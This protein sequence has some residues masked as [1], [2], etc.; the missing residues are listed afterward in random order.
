MIFNNETLREVIAASAEDCYPAYGEFDTH[1]IELLENIIEDVFATRDA[2]AE[3]EAI[4]LDDFDGDI[5]AAYQDVA[6]DFARE[7]LGDFEG[8][9]CNGTADDWA[10]TRV[11]YTADIEDYYR[12][13]PQECDEALMSCYGGLEDFDTIGEAM[14]VAVAL[15]VAAKA[16]TEMW[17]VHHDLDRNFMNLVRDAFEPG[18]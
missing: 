10:D 2:A 14:S 18:C 3:L 7:V 16:T 13:N 17:D 5:H 11:I 9:I 8:A 12:E 1:I 6:E 4:D 15:A